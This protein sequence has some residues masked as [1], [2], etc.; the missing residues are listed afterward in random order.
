MVRRKL[1]WSLMAVCLLAFVPAACGDGEEAATETPTLTVTPSPQATGTPG[2]SPTPTSEVR[3]GEGLV[4]D[5]ATSAPLLTIFAID[6]GDLRNDIPSLAVGDFN[7]DG[8]D[9]L[10]IGARF[11]HG[12]ENDRQ[13]AGEAYVIFGAADLAG[14]L[15]LAAGEQGLTIYG[16]K[17]GDNLGFGVAAAD[18]ND[19]KIDDII[20]SSPMSEGI[21]DPDYRTDRGE[22]YVIFGRSGLGGTIA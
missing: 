6:E 8:R 9:D 21:L 12:P 10:L 7:D 19:D 15:D 5:L 11:G 20:V 4:I 1:I 22:V 18:L 16:E 2:A 14:T 13:E 17:P 3:P